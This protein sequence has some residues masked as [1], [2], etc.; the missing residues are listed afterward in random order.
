MGF[1]PPNE[2][3]DSWDMSRPLTSIVILTR[4]ELAY[5]KLCVASIQA[6][7]PEPYE[8]VF[9]DNG[10]TDGTVEWLR[11]LPNAIVI[12][13]AD[14]LGFGGGCNQ[15]MAAARGAR[16]L[17]LNN[18]VVVTTGWLDALHDALDRD[19]QVGIAGPRSNRIAGIQQVD[20][21]EYDVE[22]LDGLEEW[23]ATW[24]AQHAGELA[25]FPRLI[26]FCL[27]VERA[28]VERI[29][30]F[31]L[32]YG[33]GNF[34]DDDF[35]LRAVLGGFTCVIAQGS[36]IHHFG[37]RTFVGEGIRY[38]ETLLGNR[39]RFARAWRIP[40]SDDIASG[41]YDAKRVLSRVTFDPARHFA[42]LVGVPDDGARLQLD[43]RSQ[44]I[45][46]CCDAADPLGTSEVLAAALTS[47]GPRDDVTLAIR[48]D[49]RDTV[50]FRL[51]ENAADS[52]GD[53]RLP[54]IA[55]VERCAE[56]D[57]ALFTAADA[58]VVHGR[59][60]AGR[61]LLATHVGATA[62]TVDQLGAPRVDSA[63]A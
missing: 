22:T 39:D 17:L 7:T 52:V 14:N 43:A 58:V 41:S 36:F 13:N 11:T 29:G 46:I 30:G 27:L 2:R 62:L 51:L 37:S 32:R 42:P 20:D 35:C 61:R 60:A 6:H 21:V 44:V 19:P 9:V 45:A 40:P 56:N 28:V 25:T 55:L 15:G 53:P 24:T 5:T 59:W 47:Y 63:A 4:N 48:I 1:I 8:L 38:D 12:E 57:T 10:S 54:D 16:I 31:D 34:E 23:A 18:D 49:P 50:S 26:G 33:L 3:A